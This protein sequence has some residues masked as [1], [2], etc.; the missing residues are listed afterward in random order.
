[1]SQL[2]A[3]NIS[4]IGLNLF[5]NLCHLSRIANASLEKPLPAEQVRPEAILLNILQWFCCFR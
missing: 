4:M 3:E 2:K 1:M 5:T